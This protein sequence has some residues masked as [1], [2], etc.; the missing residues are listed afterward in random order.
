LTLPELNPEPGVAG[1]NEA[2]TI[3]RCELSPARFGAEFIGEGP[4]LVFLLNK[5]EVD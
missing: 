2:A 5:L 4:F 3:G 1:E